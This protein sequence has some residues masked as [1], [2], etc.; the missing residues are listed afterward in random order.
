MNTNWIL[1]KRLRDKQQRDNWKIGFE[2]WTITSALAPS[3]IHSF[4]I[5]EEG[6]LILGGS[7][8]SSHPS[9]SSILLKYWSTMLSVTCSSR[10]GFHCK[11]IFMTLYQQYEIPTN[12]KWRVSVKPL[13]SYLCLSLRLC[14]PAWLRHGV[15]MTS[16]ITTVSERRYTINQESR[17]HL[18][19]IFA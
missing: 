18:H 6:K 19:Q 1:S 12:N 4:A 2:Q 16:T 14:N 9:S 10:R 13:V 7:F 15:G 17:K 5:I 11:S 8:R 3:P